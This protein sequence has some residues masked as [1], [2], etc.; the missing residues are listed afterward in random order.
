M[1][2]NGIIT[3]VVLFLIVLSF[4][5]WVSFSERIV[6]PGDILMRAGILAAVAAVIFGAIGSRGHWRMH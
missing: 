1:N 4:C 2:P 6:S 3:A 5:I